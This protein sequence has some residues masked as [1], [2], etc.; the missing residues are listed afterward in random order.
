LSPLAGSAEA[1]ARLV[2]VDSR[3]RFV[4]AP[5]FSGHTTLQFRAWDQTAGS[6]GGTA[7]ASSV[8]GSS[9]FSAAAEIA[10]LTVIPN[11]LPAARDDA[12]STDEDT[13]V[14]VDV[15]ANDSD[16]DGDPLTVTGLTQPTEGTATI[17]EGGVQYVPDADANGT[18]QFTYTVSDG[19]GGTATGKVSMVVLAVNDV[20]TARDDVEL[21]AED[22]SVVV[23]PRENDLAGPR[24]ENAGA[25]SMPTI[26]GAPQP[27]EATAS[28]IS[29][30]ANAGKIR[31]TPATGFAGTT[32]LLYEVC[33]DGTPALCSEASVNVTV[34]RVSATIETQPVPH[35]G[36]ASQDSADDAA[37]W[38]DPN[39]PSQSVVIGTNKYSDGTTSGGLAVYD[40]GGNQLQ[41]TNDGRMNNVDLRSGFTLAD[42]QVTLVTASQRTDGTVS[43]PRPRRIALYTL[44]PSTKTLAQIHSFTPTY[45][46]LG[47]CMYRSA[48]DFFVFVVAANGW[49]E[50]WRL[51]ESPS[52]SGRVEAAN[53]RTFRVSSTGSGDIA[54]GCVADDRLGH[55]Y[56][57]EED[58]AIWKYSAEP[59][60]GAARTQVDVVGGAQLTADVEGLAIAYGPGDTGFLIA[61]SQG[62]NSY[63]VYRREGGNA[64]V[65]S[66]KV[67]DGDVDGTSVTDGVDVTSASLG[68]AFPNG[69]FVAQDNNNAPDRQ[70]F[71]LV[72]LEQIVQTASLG[73]NA[74]ARPYTDSSPWNTPIS[75]GVVV[76]PD[77]GMHVAALG[78]PLTSNPAQF[79][80]PIY[81]VDAAT[82]RETVTLTGW[83]S[84][85]TNGGRTLVNQREGTVDLPIPVGALPAAGTDAQMIMIDPLT[86]EE[87]GLSRATRDPATGSWTGWTAYH[88]S[89]R[90]SAVPPYDA[91]GRSFVPRGAG[92]PYLAGL[93]RP[94][95]L[96][97]GRIDHAIAFAYD[98][99][100]KQFVYPATKSDGNSTGSPDVPEG[101]RLQLDP[102]LTAADLAA[103]GCIGHCLTVARALQVYGMYVIDNSRR[104]KIM[105]EYEGT[106]AW[107]GAVTAST[108]SPIPMSSFRLLSGN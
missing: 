91:T 22:G 63:S 105:V 44:D 43:P 75:A 106:A 19:Q 53:A 64:F 80:F 77:S 5:G 90:W 99:P 30:G 26:T 86:G 16:I 17:V 37:I 4:P 12:Q 31:F 107:G 32:G 35:A 24:E 14:V 96:A 57:S 81:L 94:C 41:Y 78:S 27:A 93:V 33:D 65:R 89:T 69:V 92:L 54:E 61:S 23:D 3:L 50:Q 88:Y 9:A 34:S 45:E 85:V 82:P 73:S 18:D 59:D 10:T 25:L 66:F 74:C 104:P 20:P 13:P 87:W 46:P 98:F 51:S 52:G 47:V 62:S 42:S 28:L 108:V 68:P 56:V 103:L 21:V 84:N 55:L 71:K 7:D 58:A 79:T 72:P 102:A 70:N 2:S 6:P 38:V 101:S 95:E 49:V 60:G 36:A 83:Y 76:H 29:T 1:A 97:R 40:L 100:S 15:L 11:S 39:D 67:K 8:G 48:G